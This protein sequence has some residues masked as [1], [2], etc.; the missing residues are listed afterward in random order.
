MKYIIN[1]LQ[2]NLWKENKETG[3]K[4]LGESEE[5]I[6]TLSLMASEREVIETKM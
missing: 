2:D 3:K 5:N 1:T 6:K 4:H